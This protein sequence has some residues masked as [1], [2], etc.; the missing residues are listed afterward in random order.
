MLLE[1]GERR[2][3]LELW[4]TH[5]EPLGAP[6]E[7]SQFSQPGHLAQPCSGCEGA[8]GRFGEHAAADE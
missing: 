1:Q 3:W 8:A 2:L 7:L 6:P 5:E 4:K